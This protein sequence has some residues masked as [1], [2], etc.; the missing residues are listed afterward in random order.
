VAIFQVKGS[1]V[2]A[3]SG[4]VLLINLWRLRASALADSLVDSRRMFY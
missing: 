3:A 4:S 2:R 1:V